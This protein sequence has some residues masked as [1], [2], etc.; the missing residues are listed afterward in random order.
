VPVSK[1]RITR[2]NRDFTKVKFELP[3]LFDGEFE[4]PD[5]NRLNVQEISR[6]NKDDPEAI[7]DFF[8]R[9]DCKDEAEIARTLEVDEI[10]PFLNA[11]Q[12]ASGIDLPKSGD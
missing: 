4:V 8:E 10:Q 9:T 12:A 7:A 2:K 1:K 11:W 3:E 5:F 6:L